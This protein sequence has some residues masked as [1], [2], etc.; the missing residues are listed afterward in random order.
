MAQIRKPAK[1]PVIE[2]PS[3]PRREEER[4]NLDPTKPPVTGRGAPA[5]LEKGRPKDTGRYG[6]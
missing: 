3:P 1:K 5:D 2:T 4:P 6:A